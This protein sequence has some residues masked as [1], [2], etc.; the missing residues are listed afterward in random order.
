MPRPR[1]LAAAAG[2]LALALGGCSSAVPARPTQAV[3]SEALAAAP[4]SAPAASAPASAAVAAAAT[5]L[6]VGGTDAPAGWTIVPLSDVDGGKALV[7]SARPTSGA[8]VVAFRGRGAVPVVVAVPLPGTPAQADT[9]GVETFVRSRASALVV[10]GSPTAASEA[11]GAFKAVT[12]TF[13]DHGLVAVV[14]EGYGD[15]T[16]AM[17]EV[18]LRGPG[19]VPTDVELSLGVA[20]QQ[21][22]VSVCVV[23]GESCEPPDSIV[24]DAEPGAEPS[25]ERI[26]RVQFAGRLAADAPRRAVVAGLVGQALADLG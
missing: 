2:A 9:L 12:T 6:L 1:R 16:A 20:L 24:A 3:V 26:V 11:D 21:A 4:A 17:P 22:K 19:D 15:A 14:V 8:G 13:A 25:G 7:E 18:V 10:A 23:L 5:G